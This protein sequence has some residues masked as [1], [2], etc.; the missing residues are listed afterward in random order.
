[1]SACGKLASRLNVSGY[2]N[3]IINYQTI[4]VKNDRFVTNIYTCIIIDKY[5]YE[6]NHNIYNKYQKASEILNPSMTR[7]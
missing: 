2:G 6:F 1:M 3:N 4:N 7:L 5:R